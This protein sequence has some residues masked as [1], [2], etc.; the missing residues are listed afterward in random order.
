MYSF[1]GLEDKIREAKT[2]G[3]SVKKISVALNMYRKTDGTCH[4]SQEDNMGNHWSL[5]NDSNAYYGD[6]LSWPLPCNLKSTIKQP[7]ISY[8]WT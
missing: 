4:I 2:N 8:Q 1:A 5:L 6:S 3:I 7:L